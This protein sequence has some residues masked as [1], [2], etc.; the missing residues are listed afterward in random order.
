MTIE[1]D[2]FTLAALGLSTAMAL[3]FMIEY[4]HCC[5]GCPAKQQQGKSADSE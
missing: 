5:C 2:L 1:L 3:V 4:H